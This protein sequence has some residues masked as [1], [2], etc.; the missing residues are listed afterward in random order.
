MEV[1]KFLGIL[2]SQEYPKEWLDKAL[3]VNR[4]NT[5]T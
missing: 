4:E 5:Q 3:I 2:E 1:L